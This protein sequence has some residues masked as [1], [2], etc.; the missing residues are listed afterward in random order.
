MLLEILARV[1][2]GLTLLF[3]LQPADDG[4]RYFSLKDPEPEV[5]A[6]AAEAIK[7]LESQNQP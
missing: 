1:P 3:A 2:H 5:S 7:T 6:R 4:I